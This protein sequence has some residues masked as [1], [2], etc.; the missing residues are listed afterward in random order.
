MCTELTSPMSPNTLRLLQPLVD[1]AKL[2]LE[3]V[4]EYHAI[5]S[6]SGPIRCIVIYT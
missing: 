4:I 6:L 1:G 2:L 3:S 5:L